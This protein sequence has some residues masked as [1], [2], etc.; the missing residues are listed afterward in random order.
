MAYSQ[1]TARKL[2]GGRASA[3]LSTVLRKQISSGQIPAGDFVPS[4]RRLSE[5]HGLS[6]KT[7]HR[8]LK[9]LAA[10]GLVAAEPCRGYRVLARASDPNRGCPIA[11]LLSAQATGGDWTGLNRL[12]LTSL[13]SAASRRGW[14][15]LGVGQRGLAP[16]V[17]VEQ[18]RAA[19]GWGVVVDVHG[20]HVVDLVRRA[21]MTAVMVDAWHPDAGVDA[22]VQDGFRGGLLAGRHLAELGHKQVAWFGQVTESVHSM[23]RFVGAVCGLRREGAGIPEGLIVDLPPGDRSEAARE[24]LSRPKRP[25]AVLALWRDSALEIVRAARE[26]GIE[27]GKDLDMVGWCTEE[28]YAGEFVPHFNGG[29]VPPT[30]TW[31]VE[32]LAETAVARL[33][34]RRER[35][36]LPCT[37]INIETR[38]RADSNEGARQ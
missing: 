19:Q 20:P 11:Y 2:R 30:V 9:A 10:E 15:L 33:A 35:P 27:L 1:A 8:A 34:A 17:A 5:E 36:D 28:Q 16:E 38:L 7:V 31:S 32:T 37:R 23:T 24:L 6:C 4:V 25:R 3:G 18:L 29:A 14:S 26:L 13:Q 12:I 22:V 21:G